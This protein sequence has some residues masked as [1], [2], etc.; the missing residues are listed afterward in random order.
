MAVISVNEHWE[1]REGSITSEPSARSS[2]T[3]IVLTDSITDDDQTVLAHPSIPSPGDVHP[4][5]AGLGVSS[6][7]AAPSSGGE[8]STCWMVSVEYTTFSGSLLPEQT[9]PNPLARPVRILNVTWGEYEQAMEKAYI[10]EAGV[11]SEVK[12]AVTSNVGE[13]YDPP[14]MTRHFYPI[15]TLTKNYSNLNLDD[16]AY[17]SDKLNSNTF[18]AFGLSVE[19]HQCWC[20]PIASSEQRSENGVLYYEYTFT[21][22]FRTETWNIPIA[23][24]GLFRWNATKGAPEHIIMNGVKITKPVYLDENGQPIAVPDVPGVI[25]PHYIEWR[26]KEERD[27]ADLG[28]F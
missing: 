25:Q 10:K 1:G 17:Y 5:N 21:F 19:K 26:D 9:E 22:S 12:Y 27:F 2:R 18:T 14:Q 7:T 20:G 24:M 13:P 23:N 15:L 8:L 3:F 6:V 28:I 4:N 16:I 11:F